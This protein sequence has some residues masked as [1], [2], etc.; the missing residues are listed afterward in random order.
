MWHDELEAI[1][2]DLAL[3][4]YAHLPIAMSPTEANALQR[5]E[6]K[7]DT[8]QTVVYDVRERVV[9][10]ETRE[11][12]DQRSMAALKEQ[13]DTATRLA[14]ELK[15]SNEALAS[16]TAATATDS[17]RWNVTTFLAV[18]FGTIGAV[19]ALVT[20]LRILWPPAG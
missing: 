19:A 20:I 17:R 10:I 5:I 12:A 16:K 11:E 9:R 4:D 2:R 8:L 7:V 1:R 18:V 3:I 13:Q 6:T 14:K 15:T